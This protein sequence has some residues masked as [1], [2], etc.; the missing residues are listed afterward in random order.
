[1]SVSILIQNGTWNATTNVASDTVLALPALTATPARVRPEQDGNYYRFYVVATTDGAPHSYA[2][3][4]TAQTYAI[5]DVVVA[6]PIS[7]KW[8]KNPTN[9]AM[10]EYAQNNYTDASPRRIATGTTVNELIL[11]T[12]PPPP[13]P[14]SERL[15]PPGAN[16]AYGNKPL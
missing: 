11:G 8:V 4:E 15:F 2:N 14:A 10:K 5:D 9:F 1:M 12:L 16:W 13:L 6:D 3:M 7:G